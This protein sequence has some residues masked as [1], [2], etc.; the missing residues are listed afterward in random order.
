[1]NSSH[2]HLVVG[3]LRDEGQVNGEAP[4]TRHKNVPLYPLF[5]DNY[6]VRFDDNYLDRLTD[7]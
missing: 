5:G 4:K 2:C 7:R 3:Q 6:L 1:M